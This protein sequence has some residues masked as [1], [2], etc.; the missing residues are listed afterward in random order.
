[1]NIRLR[2]IQEEGLPEKSGRLIK[3]RGR[4]KRK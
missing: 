1:M 4:E 3:N 2:N